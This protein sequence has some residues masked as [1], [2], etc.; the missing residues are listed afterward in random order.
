MQMKLDCFFLLTGYTAM[1]AA[2]SWYCVPP[3]RERSSR[4][5]VRAVPLIALRAMPYCITED[6]LAVDLA[7]ARTITVPLALFPRLENRTPAECATGV[8]SETKTE[9]TRRNG[10]HLLVR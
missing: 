9:F 1:K 5:V 10:R 3:S 4:A 8:S 2:G 7:D 6:S